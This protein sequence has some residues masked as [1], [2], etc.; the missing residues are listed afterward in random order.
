MKAL[1]TLQ[2]FRKLTPAARR[3]LAT[4]AAKL[5]GKQFRAARQLVGSEKLAA[6]VHVASGVE[7]VLIPGGRFEMGF[8]REDAAAVDT[9]FPLREHKSLRSAL[10][11]TEPQM[12][13]SREVDVAPFALARVPQ[14]EV[15]NRTEAEQALAQWGFRF[16]TEAEWEYVAREGVQQAFVLDAAADDEREQTAWGIDEMGATVWTGDLWHPNYKRAP[17]NAEPWTAG[18]GLPVYRGSFSRELMQSRDE[19]IFALSAL[20][21]EPLKKDDSQVRVRFAL[22]LAPVA[23]AAPVVKKPKTVVS[24]NPVEA[25]TALGAPTRPESKIPLASEL[26][27][28]VR[29]ALTALFEKEPDASLGLLAVPQS[30]G[31]RRRW[32]GLDKPGVFEKKTRVTVGGA[33]HDVPLWRACTLVSKANDQQQLKKLASPAE[34]VQVLYETSNNR[35]YDPFYFDDALFQSLVLEAGAD[36]A[37]WAEALLEQGARGELALLYPVAAAGRP[38]QP[39]WLAAYGV[40]AWKKDATKTIWNAVDASVREQTKLKV[41]NEDLASTSRFRDTL[42]F[43]E[44]F[45]QP[46]L[47]RAC[48]AYFTSKEGKKKHGTSTMRF[49]LGSLGELCAKSKSLRG[50]LDT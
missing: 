1:A 49:W 30:A 22:K 28:E 41:L 8:T 33:T 5:L 20:R 29:A 23:D 27:T 6:V 32:L 10:K 50:A 4:D 9:Q 21:V 2:T 12:T 40:S 17:K 26:A 38:I 35:G 7:F 15:V 16:P 13:P 39:A 3:T 44:L 11:K 19:L 47:A 25:L 14:Q 42:L 34:L 31:A 46:E 36:N 18:G 45:P 48:A 24:K 37:K 43:I